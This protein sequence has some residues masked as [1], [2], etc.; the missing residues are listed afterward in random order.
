MEVLMGKSS[1]NEPFSMAMLNNQR[2]FPKE[3]PSSFVDFFDVSQKNVTKNH[4][5]LT[6]TFKPNVASSLP[7]AVVQRNWA[8]PGDSEIHRG[9]D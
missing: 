6:E 1:V 8:T 7:T 3:S 4:Q 9:I 5:I 2:V